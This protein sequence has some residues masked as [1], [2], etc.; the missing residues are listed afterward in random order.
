MVT[1][2][3]SWWGSLG[4]NCFQL[5]QRCSVAEMKVLRFEGLSGCKALYVGHL[6]KSMVR[7]EHQESLISEWIS[8]IHQQLHPSS[9]PQMISREEYAAPTSQDS[10]RKKDGKAMSSRQRLPPLWLTDLMVHRMCPFIWA[11]VVEIHSG[12][13]HVKPCPDVSISQDS[14]ERE[15]QSIIN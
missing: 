6:K 1:A 15:T 9:N 2:L 11:S 10:G 5:P 14:S 4:S 3:G 8:Q 12:L 13:R 7:E